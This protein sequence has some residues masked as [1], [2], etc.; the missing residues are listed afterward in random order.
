MVK[1]NVPRTRNYVFV[2]FYS[3]PI[4]QNCVIETGV[5]ESVLG[6]VSGR[7]ACLFLV[8]LLWQRRKPLNWLGIGLSETGSC[9]NVKVVKPPG[10]FKELSTATQGEIW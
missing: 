5:V 10:I 4:Q 6:N 9:N 8:K 2:T 1:I 3:L 7:G